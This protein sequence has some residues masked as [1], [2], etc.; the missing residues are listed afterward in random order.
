MIKEVGVPLPLEDPV[1]QAV[2]TT[3]IQVGSDR[4]V[5]VVKPFMG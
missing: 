5:N 1:G 2:I 4:E 3:S